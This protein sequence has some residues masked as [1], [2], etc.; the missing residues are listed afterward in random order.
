MSMYRPHWM[1]S[2]GDPGGY[3]GHQT[4]PPAL[5]PP[6]PHQGSSW[7]TPPPSTRLASSASPPSSYSSSSAANLG[8]G[9][10]GANSSSASGNQQLPPTPPK[11]SHNVQQTQSQD[12][13]L[14][15]HHTQLHSHLHQPKHEP[16]SS[17]HYPET[18]PNSSCLMTS[19]SG[20]ASYE[21]PLSREDPASGRLNSDQGTDQYN[22]H[23]LHH[24][25]KDNL[26]TTKSELNPPP[27]SMGPTTLDIKNQ[28][29]S[30]TISHGSTTYDHHP[31]SSSANS[32]NA[33]A[34]PGIGSSNEHDS[35]VPN[36]YS[37]IQTSSSTAYSPPLHPH[38]QGQPSHHS[39]HHNSSASS[40]LGAPMGGDSGVRGSA[41]STGGSEYSANNISPPIN[42]SGMPDAG[43][44]NY[45]S[46]GHVGGIRTNSTFNSSSN[47]S[48]GSS[49]GKNRPNAGKYTVTCV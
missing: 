1:P 9:G 39:G 31:P 30:P 32:Y 5:H 3:N 36:A 7:P 26:L 14:G 47:P 48:K 15:H 8:S 4:Q 44:S 22:H 45:S 29:Q 34:P 17:H 21:T 38:H 16:G 18:Q 13:Q 40:L 28:P 42:H 25:S 6:A 2:V 49:K 43:L 11:D 12:H 37:N 19:A 23:H 35:Y 24:E 27:S 33:G 10:G 20:S 46:S 41:S